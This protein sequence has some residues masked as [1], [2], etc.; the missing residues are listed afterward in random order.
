MRRNTFSMMWTKAAK[1]AG[2]TSTFHAL[3]HYYASLL[4]RHGEAVD[5][6]LGRGARAD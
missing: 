4:I 6:V 3:R 1:T 2:T 5:V